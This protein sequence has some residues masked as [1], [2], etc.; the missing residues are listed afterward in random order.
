MCPKLQNIYTRITPQLLTAQGR[1]VTPSSLLALAMADPGD[2]RA[3]DCK[4]VF[5]PKKK[6]AQRVIPKVADL[7]PGPAPV[8]PPP[9]CVVSKI[10]P[11]DLI[12]AIDLETND[13]VRGNTKTWIRDQFGLLSKTPPETL[14]TLRAVQLGWAIGTSR[15]DMLVQEKL[16]QP[17]GFAITTDATRKHRIAHEVAASTGEPL[18]N[19]LETM[20]SEVFDSC[21]RGG[22][23]CSHHLGFDAGVIYEELGR[24]GL[25]HL[26][27]P[28]SEVVRHG[29]CTMDPDVASWARDMIGIGDVP[30][31]ISA[32]LADL[33]RGLVPE[34]QEL[35]QGH[36]SAGNDAVMHLALCRELATRC[37]A[38]LD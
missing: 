37:Q 18:R 11:C 12:V 17:C 6:P 14:S 25:D 27:E 13:L 1:G 21:A 3:L 20:V 35:L 5:P 33:V 36:H 4:F 38:A 16:V 29:I 32:G 28:W 26:K 23:V 24:S 31:S 2:K 30:R 8:V 10:I 15:R 34:S 9:A 22:R 7:M 19:V